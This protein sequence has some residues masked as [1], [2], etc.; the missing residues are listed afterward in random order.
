MWHFL[1]DIT[2]SIDLNRSFSKFMM[3]DTMVLKVSFFF[4][5]LLFLTYQ[6]YT[7]V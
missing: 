5:T 2:E 4:F 3:S 6:I 7:F 1:Y